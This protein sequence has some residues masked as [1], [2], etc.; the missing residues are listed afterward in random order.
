MG[1]GKYPL[2]RL[3]RMCYNISM[4]DKQ[5]YAHMRVLR[6]TQKNL[7]IAAALAEKSGIDLIDELVKQELERLQ[8]ERKTD[9]Q[10]V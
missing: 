1:V 2:D 7:R 6:S 5:K 9:A 3:W 4:E 8:K 10:S